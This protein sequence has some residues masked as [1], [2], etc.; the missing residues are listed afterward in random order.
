MIKKYH[1]S[2]AHEPQHYD[3]ITEIFKN[4]YSESPRSNQTKIK[5]EKKISSPVYQ[6]KNQLQDKQDKTVKL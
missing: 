6:F 3:K 1:S 5:E 4:L 2:F